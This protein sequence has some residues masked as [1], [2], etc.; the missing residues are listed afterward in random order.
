MRFF[1]LFL[2]LSVCLSLCPAS[3]AAEIQP[4]PKQV[5][6]TFT[7]DCT[8]GNTPEERGQATCF[9]AY[10][11]KYGMEYPFANVKEIFEQDDLT[12][13]NLEGTFYDYEANRANKTYTFRAPTSYADILT[14][15]SIEAVSIGNNHSLD[16]G[17]AGEMSTIAALEERGIAWFGTNEYANGTYIY[18][19]DGVKI[20][21]VS[22]YISYWWGAGNAAIIQQCFSDLKA[23]GCHLIIACIHGGVEYDIRHDAN[24]ER[25]ANKFIEYGADIII[26]HHPHTIQGI[27]VE[28][29]RTTLWSLGNFSF[30]GNS[31]TTVRKGILKDK[32]NLNTYIAQFT[33][34]FDEN[35]RYLGHQL[36]II[37]CYVTGTNS[38]V[39]NFQPI[40]VT[41]SDAE[42]VMKAIQDDTPFRRLLLNPYVES[43]G[44]IQEFVP[45]PIR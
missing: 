44:A 23:A 17:A 22:C 6:I 45:A 12:V 21:F 35:S 43:V 26:G 7:G 10:I 42:K 1:A 14:L 30:G 33:F 4:A 34:S 19:K 3:L 29:G 31:K 5:V 13:I 18:E 38:E 37:P 2:A 16:Y 32:L 28:N 40:L 8:L 36:N 15:S 9:E 41:G 25:M 11:E 39:N 24:Q 20:G 27:R